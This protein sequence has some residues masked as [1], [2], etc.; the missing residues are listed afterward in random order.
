MATGP[1]FANSEWFMPYLKVSDTRKN[2]NEIS[3]ADSGTSVKVPLTQAFLD[4]YFVTR[5][6][7]DVNNEPGNDLCVMQHSNKVCVIGLAAGHHLFRYCLPPTN[8]RSKVENA[9]VV[10]PIKYEA[11]E[12]LFVDFQLTRSFNLL[13]TK[14]SGRRKRGCHAVQHG[15]QCIGFA[16]CSRGVRHPLLCGL[17]GR[18][19]EA[20][21]RLAAAGGGGSDGGPAA[22]FELAERLKSSHTTHP[23]LRLTAFGHPSTAEGPRGEVNSSYLCVLMPTFSRSGSPEVTDSRAVMSD[24]TEGNMVIRITSKGLLDSG[25]DWATYRTFRNL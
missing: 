12:L 6:F 21:S 23:P 13:E 18:I 5:Y 11:H 9:A 2:A 20:N 22:S 15:M 8:K 16:S 10:E 4:R 14:I 1:D 25:M 7:C 19:Y 3:N 17:P 24:I